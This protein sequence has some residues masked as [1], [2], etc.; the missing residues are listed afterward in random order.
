MLLSLKARTSS[1]KRRAARFFA[2]PGGRCPFRFRRGRFEK[3]VKKRG[4]GFFQG[5]IC[6]ISER[7][8]SRF[9]GFRY[10]SSAVELARGCCC[11]LLS[12]LKRISCRRNAAALKF[13]LRSQRKN[14]DNCAAGCAVTEVLVTF[15][16][17]VA[18]FWGRLNGSVEGR[19]WI[20]ESRGCG[21]RN[22]ASSRNSEGIEKM[23]HVK[24]QNTLHVLFFEPND[25]L[26]K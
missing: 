7:K 14:G 3:S 4:Q 12:P 11:F 16:T 8:N 20:E 10:F 26:R 13:I 17:V 6:S 24:R 15:S 23:F 2:N 22:A 19:S 9:V 5:T 25:L 18:P 1:G 21:E